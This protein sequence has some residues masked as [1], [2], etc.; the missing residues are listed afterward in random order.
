MRGCGVWLIGL[1]ICTLV[2]CVFPVASAETVR[3]RLVWSGLMLTVPGTLLV[4]GIRWVNRAEDRD[5]IAGRSLHLSEVAT[6]GSPPP[7]WRERFGRFDLAD[8]NITGWVLFLTSLGVLGLCVAGLVALREATGT[9][10]DRWPRKWVGYALLGVL[11]V[12]FA[13]VRW[14][15]GR[16]GVSIYR[17]RP[18]PGAADPADPGPSDPSSP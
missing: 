13:G 11:V 17:P 9:A 10:P 18:T 4:V 2:M 7:G 3:E 15:L 8:L 1:G 5:R 16:C 12:F 14:L 6:D